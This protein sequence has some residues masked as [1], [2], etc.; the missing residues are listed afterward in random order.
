MI[1][2]K[3]SYKDSIECIFQESITLATFPELLSILLN[4]EALEDNEVVMIEGVRCISR[5]VDS[6]KKAHFER[7]D[8][9]QKVFNT[10]FQMN[11]DNNEK[12]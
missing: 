8:S 4:V 10:F 11:N 6:K 12:D 3:F 7:L 5:I 2:T 1:F 9:T